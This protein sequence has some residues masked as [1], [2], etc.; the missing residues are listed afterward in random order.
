MA[1]KVVSKSHIVTTATQ[2]IAG[3]NK[4]L[5]STTPV[6][7]LGSP[8][9]PAEITS[10]LQSIV[11]L[12]TDVDTAKA[13]TKAKLAMEAAN[14]PSLRTFMDAFVTYLKAAYGASPD[15]LADFGIHPKA[16]AALTVQQKAVAAAKRASTRAARH[17][18]GAKQKASV[19]GDVTGVVVTPVTAPK[20]PPSPAPT[21]TPVSPAP[22]PAPVSPTPVVP[23]VHLA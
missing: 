1:T 10:K 13:A 14:M 22:T 17:T 16:R 18:M 20:P 8:S 12:R 2:L 19:K 5:T 6:V 9:T 23:P 7:L 3:V 15:V 4:H 21:P 11:T